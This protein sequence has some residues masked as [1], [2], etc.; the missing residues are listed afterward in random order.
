[1][2]AVLSTFDLLV[3]EWFATRFGQ[4]TEPQVEGWPRIR[5]GRDVLIAAPTGSGKTLAA[6]LIAID[7]LVR[8]GKWYTSR[9]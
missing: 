5:E 7:G 3:A 2:K 8:R 6:F 4:P 1:M 9:R